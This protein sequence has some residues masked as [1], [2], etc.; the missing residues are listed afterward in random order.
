MKWTIFV[1]DEGAKKVEESLE[2]EKEVRFGGRVVNVCR[3]ANAEV[4]GHPAALL[5]KGNLFD[6]YKSK[7]LC[8]GYATIRR[9]WPKL[10]Y[11]ERP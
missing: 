4:E 7:K 3:S 10:V 5:L 2:D 1:T 11:H 9:G 6:Y 8:K